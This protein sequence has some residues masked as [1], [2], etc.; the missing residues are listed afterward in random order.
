MGIE[1]ISG[2]KRACP[3]KKLSLSYWE[4]VRVKEIT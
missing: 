4:T 3:L 2:V 1:V